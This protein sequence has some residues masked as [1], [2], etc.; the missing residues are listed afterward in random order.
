MNQNITVGMFQCYYIIIMIIITFESELRVVWN[1]LVMRLSD[2]CPKCQ[3][4]THRRCPITIPDE[5]LTIFCPWRNKHVGS[6]INKLTMTCELYSKGEIIICCP[7]CVTEWWGDKV[8][9]CMVWY[10]SMGIRFVFCLMCGFL[11]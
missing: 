2:A 4:S 11:R 1:N 10:V 3:H 9:Y 7:N 5:S 6:G 8:D